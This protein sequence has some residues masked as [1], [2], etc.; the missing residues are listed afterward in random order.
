MLRYLGIVVPEVADLSA[1]QKAQH[2]L[3]EL[4]LKGASVGYGQVKP[5]VECANC[6]ADSAVAS[7]SLDLAEKTCAVSVPQSALCYGDKGKDVSLLHD[8][9][10]KLGFMQLRADDDG[11]KFSAW[12]RDALLTFQFRHIHTFEHRMCDTLGMYGPE[13]AAAL[14]HE[15]TLLEAGRRSNACA[16]SE[17]RMRTEARCVAAQNVRNFRGGN[18]AQ[19]QHTKAAAADSN[20]KKVDRGLDV[21]SV[22]RARIIILGGRRAGA[23]SLVKAF[24]GKPFNRDGGAEDAQHADV[25]VYG[26]SVSLCGAPV[27]L[28][29]TEKRATARRTPFSSKLYA[30]SDAAVLVCFNVR[31]SA[32]LQEDAVACLAEV[33]SLSAS[34]QVSNSLPIILVGCQAD[35]FHVSG[36]NNQPEEDEGMSNAAS[37]AVPPLLH[38]VSF[39]EAAAFAAAR[40][41]IYVE[42]SA[43]RDEVEAPFLLAALAIARNNSWLPLGQAA[44]A[45]HHAR[46]SDMKLREANYYQGHSN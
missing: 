28:R 12:T 26:S 29:L 21:N 14:E 41:M 10:T 1:R 20:E 4:A 44:N 24:L 8:A 42:T 17:V 40:G 33:Y 6:A 19:V 39:D 35:D 23:S 7:K 5:N 34:R 2:I 30:G 27:H 9:L 37:A 36:H 38:A 31:D 13:T 43:F 22:H 16:G 18:T 3:V 46:T 25:A 15:L 11:E 45:R 32:S